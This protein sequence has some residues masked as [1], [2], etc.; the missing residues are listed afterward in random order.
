MKNNQEIAHLIN[1]LKHFFM[2]HWRSSYG[3]FS[4]RTSDFKYAHHKHIIEIVK[5]YD[6]VKFI[7]IM[8]RKEH[9]DRQG[10]KNIAYFILANF[11]PV[12]CNIVF[13][14]PCQ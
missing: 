8:T 4:K 2:A 13:F 9:K 3:H 5:Q 12:I 1:D 14:A 10:N 7:W 11:D 6:T